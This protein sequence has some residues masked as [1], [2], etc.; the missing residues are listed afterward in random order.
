VDA[1]ATRHLSFD[2]KWIFTIPPP[3]NAPLYQIST[4]L[5]NALLSYWWFSKFSTAVLRKEF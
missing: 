4:Q 2:Q 5:G 1:V 3:L